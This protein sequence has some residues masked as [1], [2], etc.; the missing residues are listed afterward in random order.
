MKNLLADIDKNA[1]KVPWQ[2]YTV[3]HGVES[4]EVLVPLKS[5]AAFETQIVKQKLAPRQAGIQFVSEH[6]G[7][8]KK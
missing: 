2:S 1:G 5:A 3:K 8:L 7:I 4:I 6:G